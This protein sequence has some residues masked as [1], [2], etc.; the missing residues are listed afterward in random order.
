M[1][2]DDAGGFRCDVDV[3]AVFAD[4]TFSSGIDAYVDEEATE[5]AFDVFS[6]EPLLFLKRIPFFENVYKNE[7][8]TRINCVF[9]CNVWKKFLIQHM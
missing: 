4:G 7:G 3:S 1:G 9:T 8:Y 2:E 6:A 5:L